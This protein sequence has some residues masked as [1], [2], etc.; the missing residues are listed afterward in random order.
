[1]RR[2]SYAL[3]LAVFLLS[4]PAAAQKTCGKHE[5]IVKRLESQY[6]ETRKDV[7]MNFNGILIEIFAS[8]KG[9]FSIVFTRPNG[10]SCLV[11][12]G[13]NWEHLPDNLASSI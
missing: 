10:L 7:G 2:W 8:E 9:T 5:D 3:F 11:A 12:A 13:T 1:M 6:Q 4:G